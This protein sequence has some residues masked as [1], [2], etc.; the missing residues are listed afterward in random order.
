VVAKETKQ[1]LLEQGMA[2]LLRQGYHDLGIA[3]VLEPTGVPKGSFYHHFQSKEDFGLQA[4]DLYMSEVHA[5]LDACLGDERVPPLQRVRS[6]FE[7]TQDK[8]R[9]EGYMAA[10]DDILAVLAKHEVD[11]QTQK[12]V[13][14]IA[15][16]LK[17]EMPQSSSGW[18]SGSAIRVGAWSMTHPST[19]FF[20]RAAQKWECP[21]LSSTRHKRSVVPSASSV[22]PGLKT[23]CAG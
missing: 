10:V 5:G 2:M 11:E 23:V 6:F 17:G 3:A 20:D 7:A 21:R 19:P 22:A 18:H 4:I 8:Y 15:Y 13:L 9:G 1:I 14:A 16:S 12:D